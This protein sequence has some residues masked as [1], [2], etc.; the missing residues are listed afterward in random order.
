MKTGLPIVL[1]VLAS[2]VM[3]GYAVVISVQAVSQLGGTGVVNVPKTDIRVLRVQVPPTTI[4][5]VTLTMSSTVSGTYIVSVTVNV[6]ACTATG[7]IT[8]T[9]S[10]TPTTTTVSLSPS[11]N[12]NNP[13]RVTVVVTPT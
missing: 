5:T 12:F 13:A 6:G 3:I 2:F 10:S 9:L 7:S 11:C 4:N 8:V 1:L